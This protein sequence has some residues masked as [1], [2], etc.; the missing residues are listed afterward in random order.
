M[1]P[2]AWKQYCEPTY[3]WPHYTGSFDNAGGAVFPGLN[4]SYQ[5]P[6]SCTPTAC[7]SAKLFTNGLLYVSGYMSGPTGGGGADFY[8]VMYVLGT[9]TD[10]ANSQSSTF[11]Y[12][13]SAAQGLQLTQVMLVRQSW[14]DLVV[15]AFP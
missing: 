7:S 14:Q 5:S 11:Y 3:A 2:N 15:R 4:S 12:N 6:S 9:T 10:T 1:P 13:Q 8:G